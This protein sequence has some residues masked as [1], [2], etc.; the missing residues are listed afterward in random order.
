MERNDWHLR[1]ADSV[2]AELKTDMYTGLASKEAVRRRRREG[3][4]RIWYIR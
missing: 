3:V 1:E 2:L 4:N